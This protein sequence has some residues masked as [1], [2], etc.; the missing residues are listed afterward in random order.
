MVVYFAKTYTFNLKWQ[1]KNRNNCYGIFIILIQFILFLQNHTLNYQILFN[2]NHFWSSPRPI[3]IGQLQALPLFH[4][5]PIYLIV[6]KGSY[7]LS[8]DISS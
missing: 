4:L 1:N 5:Q 7:C 6:Y 3:S 8:R 2:L